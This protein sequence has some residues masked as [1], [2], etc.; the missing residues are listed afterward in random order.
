MSKQ[1]NK[2]KQIMKEN[3]NVKVNK[4]KEKKNRIGEEKKGHTL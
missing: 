2:V 4:T 3:F 1:S